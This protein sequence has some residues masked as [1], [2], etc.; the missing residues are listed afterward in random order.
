MTH[1]IEFLPVHFTAVPQ[2]DADEV[3]SPWRL[4]ICGFHQQGILW[5]REQTIMC[6]LPV[7]CSY[8]WPSQTGKPVQLYAATPGLHRLANQC[9]YMRPHLAF[10]DWQT[11]AVICGHTWPSQTGKPVE[12]YAATP[13]LHRL[14]NQCSYMRPHLAFTDW[15]TSAVTCC[16]TWPLQAMANQWL[17]AATSGLHTVANQWLYAA[18]SGLHTVANQWLY[19]ATSGLHTVANQW[20]YAATSGLHTVANQWLYAATSGLHTVANQWLYAATSGL[21]TVANQWLYA[22]T[23]GLHTVANQCSVLWSRIQ[24]VHHQFSSCL[25]NP[26]NTQWWTENSKF[27]SELGRSVVNQQLPPS[28]SHPHKPLYPCWSVSCYC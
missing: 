14:A 28:H 5:K 20:L 17:Y 18:T 12:L 13:G 1:R 6:M 21:H 2:H 4:L 3:G 26:Q 19:A 27:D 24:Q 11:S 22:A 9:S 15:Q 7:I 16:H 25:V 23:S 8:T 10:T